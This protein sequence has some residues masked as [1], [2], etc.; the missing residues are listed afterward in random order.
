MNYASVQDRQKFLLSQLSAF[1]ADHYIVV[2]KP[3]AALRRKGKT[4]L[5]INHIPRTSGFRS[6]GYAVEDFMQ[7]RLWNCLSKYN[8]DG[9]SITVKCKSTKYHYVALYDVSHAELTR[10][11]E[12]EGAAPCFVSLLS[13]NDRQERFYSVVLRFCVT[14][15]KKDTIYAKKVA[16]SFQVKYGL[17]KIDDLEACIPLAGFWD[18]KSGTLVKPSRVKSR[19]CEAC[20]KRLATFVK[21]GL[22][23]LQDEPEA[24]LIDRS[25]NDDFYFES[26]LQMMVYNANKAGDVVDEAD[27]ERR[28]INKLVKEHYH[29]DQ[30][31]GFFIQREMPKVEQCDF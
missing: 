16:S 24:P 2:V 6:T 4:D 18:K 11:V 17:K 29:I 5:T 1:D 21:G 10:L 22:A 19:D 8:S 14:D 31:K 27:I 30:I 9:Y 3:N 23:D 13:E 26:C 7:S 28:L 25:G 20:T 15:H 12:G